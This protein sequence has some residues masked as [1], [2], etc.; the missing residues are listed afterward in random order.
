VGDRFTRTG[1]DTRS[2]EAATTVWVSNPTETV[3]IMK[4]LLKAMDK[5]HGIED[6]NPIPSDINSTDLDS[7]PRLP[8]SHAAF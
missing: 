2:R 6:S 7:P 8:F 5:A 4:K 1:N 3:Y